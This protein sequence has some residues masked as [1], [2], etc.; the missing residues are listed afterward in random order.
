MLLRELLPFCYAESYSR[1]ITLLPVCCSETYHRFVMPRATSVLLCRELLPVSHPLVYFEFI[2]FSQKA[3]E[4]PAR[5]TSS[6]QQ[7]LSRLCSCHARLRAHSLSFATLQ[8]RHIK[9]CRG[10]TPK[11]CSGCRK[12]LLLFPLGRP[13]PD[14]CVCCVPDC[15]RVHY[16]VHGEP[17]RDCVHTA[18]RELLPACRELLPAC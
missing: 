8:L 18:R 16:D 12:Q 3:I 13:V 6:W 17:R 5:C 11:M 15:C 10:A 4:S 9:R 14:C 1:F 7:L 2:P